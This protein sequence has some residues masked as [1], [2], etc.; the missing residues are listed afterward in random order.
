MAHGTVSDSETLVM[1]SVESTKIQPGDKKRGEGEKERRKR[2][3][4][5][6]DGEYRHRIGEKRKKEEENERLGGVN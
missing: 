3:D 4:V 2:R 5:N 6:V 1:R